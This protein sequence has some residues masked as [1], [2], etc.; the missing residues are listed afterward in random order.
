MSLEAQALLVSAWWQMFYLVTANQKGCIN[1]SFPLHTMNSA[2][3]PVQG[4]N[5]S[6]MFKSNYENLGRGTA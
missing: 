5:I 3:Q 2:T 4:S 1:V 6:K